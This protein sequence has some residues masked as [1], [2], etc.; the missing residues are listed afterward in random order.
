MQRVTPISP[1]PS[2]LA[3]SSGLG[4]LRFLQS[5]RDSGSRKLPRPCG[6]ANFA[7]H[8]ARTPIHPHPALVLRLAQTP[9]AAAVP[10]IL[11]RL[12]HEELPSSADNNGLNFFL[13][14]LSED[15]DPGR[16]LG[17]QKLYLQQELGPL[18]E[19]W[20]VVPGLCAWRVGG[21]EWKGPSW[22]SDSTRGGRRRR[23]SSKEA[24]WGA[25][26]SKH[27]SKIFCRLL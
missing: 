27:S 20:N 25:T 21:M 14:G 15:G 26:S 5:G 23:S 19:V 16:I 11:G 7:A 17:V 22:P 4:G 24:W 3:K 8:Q 9:G 6:K 13:L 2:N 10:P 18:L 12:T 1:L